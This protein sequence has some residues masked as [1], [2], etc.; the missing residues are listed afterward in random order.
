MMRPLVEEIVPAPD[1]VSCCASLEGLPYRLFLDSANTASRFG[2]YSFLTADPVAIVRSKDRATECLD[3]LTGA[4]RTTDGDPLTVVRELMSPHVAEQVPDLP[5]FQGGAA[6]FVAYDW[7]LT[8]ERLPAP[9]F[10]DLGL[11][12]LV[13]GMYDWVIA[14]DH[15]SSRAWLI[16]TGMPETSEEARRTRAASRAA[17][18][19]ERIDATA[20]PSDR[21]LAP[22]HPRPV[23]PSYSVEPVWWPSS[24]DLYSSFTRPAYLEAVARVREYIF[25]GDIFQANLSQRFEAPLE[26]SA[27]SFYTRLRARNAA[28]FAAF[29]DFPEVVMVSASPER[30]LRVDGH[31]M[32]ET[33]PIKGT[34]PRGFGPEHDAALG[35]ALAES[36]KDRAENLMIVDLM[37]NDLSRVCAPHSVRVSEL[38]ALERYATVYHLVSTVVGKLAPDVDAIDLLRAAFPGGSITGAPKL[39]AMEIIAELEPSKRG[40]YCGSI[41]YWSVT[42]ELDTS[43]AIRTAVLQDGRVYFSAGGGIVADSDPEQEYRETLDKARAMIDVLSERSTRASV[44]SLQ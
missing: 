30:F 34:R 22:P 16:S 4:R 27:W 14:W 1:P 15:A 7:G 44:R 39:R 42:G 21:A 20:G 31:G 3:R 5:P 25:A 10:D 33:R 40:V 13:M 35:Q 12:D 11:P 17:L 19:K 32:V 26:E 37:R 6:G 2:R 29:V 38:F 9:R 41:G 18:V 8:L 43:I 28:P 36:A 24:F 23:A